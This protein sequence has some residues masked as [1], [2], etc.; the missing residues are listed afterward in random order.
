MRPSFY[1]FA[2]LLV[3][4]ACTKDNSMPPPPNLDYVKTKLAF[5]CRHEINNLPTL[6]P[7]ADE[8]FKYARFLQKQRGEKDYNQIARYYRIAA[9][10]DHY[11]ANHNLQ[12]L[13]SE[14]WASSPYPQRETIELA[15]TLVG[16]GIP[17]G[18]YDI[19]YYLMRGY[20]FKQNQE[21]ALRFFRK[22]ADLGNP[23]AQYYVADKLSPR[24]MAPD[25]ANQLYE[26]A[27]E[28]GYGEAAL[29]LGFFLK[30]EK[31]YASA[32]EMF[33]KGVSAGNSLSSLKLENA[34][35]G[36][37]P[38]DELDYLG[39]PYD[40]E[41]S[42][43]YSLIRSFLDRNDGRNPKVPDIDD[44]VPLPPAPLPDWDGSFQ[45]EKE[46]QLVPPKPSEDLIKRLCEDKHLD[47]ATG[48]PLPLPPKA[49]LGSRAKTGEICPETGEWCA[50]SDGEVLSYTATR[51]DKGRTM[52]RYQ[53]WEPRR[54][55]VLDDF[56]PLRITYWNVEWQLVDYC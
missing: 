43:R 15:N 1:T 23:G 14:G 13:V 51:V 29:T 16:Q 34:F 45:W 49:A 37:K 22:A 33:Q 32:A 30:N 47:P 39:L 25:I 28:Q 4:S 27:A 8:L 36:L 53:H 19:G 17:I 3:L 24:D 50:W 9:A 42:R 10:Y 21:V 18:Y 52:P 26:C 12:Q 55:A 54:F 31:R 38:T 20:G 44:I 6:N 2:L 11:K 35:S 46:Q 7:H 48:L 56:L 5:T 40:E 41:R